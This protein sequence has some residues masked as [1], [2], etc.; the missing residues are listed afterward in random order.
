MTP[1]HTTCIPPL[2]HTAFE[3]PKL[4]TFPGGSDG[5]ESTCDVG[6]LGSLPGLGRS[7][8]GGHGNPLQYPCLENPMDGEAWWAAVYGVAQSQTQLKR[9][10]SS[11]SSRAPLRELPWW[12][13]SQESTCH[14][15]DVCLIPGSG[16]SPGGG[17][18]NP[19]Q[20]SCLENPMDGGAWW[21]TVPK[22]AKSRT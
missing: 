4:K 21:A 5:K 17:C 20:Y 2:A 6:D 18:G 10:S 15:K 19:L 9:L 16:R 11:S 3:E 1:R 8:G 14:A 7:P 13:S 12:F 22:V